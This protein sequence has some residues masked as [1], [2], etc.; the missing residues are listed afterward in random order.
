MSVLYR[1]RACGTLNDFDG[2]EVALNEE[3]HASGRVVYLTGEPDD[4]AS[5][6]A[7]GVKEE[8][9]APFNVE[10]PLQIARSKHKTR[11][12]GQVW[13]GRVELADVLDRVEELTPVKPRGTWGTEDDV[14]A[15][16]PRR[17]RRCEFRQ[18]PIRH[19]VRGNSETSAVFPRPG[20]K[21]PESWGS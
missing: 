5:E 20:V 12:N 13:A 16:N 7:D 1:C 17:Y 3:L 10:M 11:A 19:G 2:Q 4:V 15:Q 14:L 18:T 8:P 21:P 9:D 6:Y